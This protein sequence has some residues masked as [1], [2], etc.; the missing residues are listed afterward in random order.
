[1]LFAMPATYR[2]KLP[3]T[4]Q[5]CCPVGIPHETEPRAE[6]AVF[7]HERARAVL[8]VIVVVPDAEVQRQMVVHAPVVVV[9]RGIGPE[10]RTQTARQNRVELNLRRAVR[11]PLRKHRRPLD[12]RR[13]AEDAPVAARLMVV[14][15]AVVVV[16]VVA[17]RHVVRPDAVRRDRK[18][19]SPSRRTPRC[20]R[21]SPDH[22]CRRRSATSIGC[23]CATDR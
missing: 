22:R 2:P 18:F 15:E 8:A 19:T 20:C 4:D 16:G 21:A 17:E 3:V 5:I 23:R 10:I 7:G 9:E 6:R 11:Q 1:M 14:G 12:D 13:R